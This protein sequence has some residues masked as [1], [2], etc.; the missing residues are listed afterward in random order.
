MVRIDN[1]G[2]GPAY[3]LTEVSIKVDGSNYKAFIANE[4][5]LIE[6]GDVAGLQYPFDLSEIEEGEITAVIIVKYGS[7]K[8]TLEEYD[9][10]SGPIAEVTYLDNS[11][12]TAKSA[13]YDGSE[14]VMLVTL[15][16]N[17]NETAYVS[18]DIELV[19]DGETVRVRGPKNDEIAP[20]TMV[21]HE[22]FVELTGDDLAQNQK[23]MVYLDYGER[24]GF[25]VNSAIYA[26]PLE[27]D[28]FPWWLLILLLVLLIIAGVIYYYWTRN[29]KPEGK[30]PFKKG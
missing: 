5:Q 20:H 12:V 13:K 3:F 7:G 8:N 1:L 23:V 29:K 4:T 17:Q 21:T 30:R 28:M 22:Y 14:K 9:Y 16:N 2:D 18:S 25:L 15:K 26:L 27:Y 6:Y 19:L 10:Y 24:E 11:N